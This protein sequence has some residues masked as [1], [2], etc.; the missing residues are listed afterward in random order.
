[1]I[2]NAER[3]ANGYRNIIAERIN[4]FRTGYVFTPSVFYDIVNNPVQVSRILRQLVQEGTIRK[5]SKGHFDR[6]KQTI[7]GV[8]A[9]S[10]DW[11]LQEF[12]M[13][14]KTIIGYISGAQ[15]FASLG[16]TTQ[17]SGNYTIGSNTYRRAVRRGMITIRFVLQQNTLT[18]ENIP[19]LQILDA[20]RFIR[21]IPACTPVEA[22]TILRQQIQN[23]DA[24]SR[25]QLAT[26]ALKYTPYVRAIVGAML[27][28]TDTNT[29][30]LY[31]SLNIASTYRIGL[32][33]DVLP[34]CKKWR[35]V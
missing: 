19:L 28:E 11:M 16:L 4:R 13:D 7:F 5:V 14:G 9:P 17:I 1:R 35:I 8:M 29:T 24:A 12:L 31:R 15:A 30:A 32:T 27:D 6:P 25:R 26:L 33:P 20:I 2:T 18:R 10:E 3:M 34:N 22:C 21:E 23:K